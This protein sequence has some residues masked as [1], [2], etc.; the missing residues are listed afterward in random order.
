MRPTAPAGVAGGR[1][2]PAETHAL[3]AL[4]LLQHYR[5]HA[6]LGTD[7]A[8]VPLDE[9]HRGL[10]DLREAAIAALHAI[11]PCAGEHERAA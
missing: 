4:M 6:R 8:L 10:W 7:G 2:N 9:Q 5:R 1:E 3:L 11:A